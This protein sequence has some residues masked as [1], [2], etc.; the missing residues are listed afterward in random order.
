VIISSS[1]LAGFASNTTPALRNISWRALDSD[2]NVI[3]TMISDPQL[4]RLIQ[5]ILTIYTGPCVN[6][7]DN[8]GILSNNPPFLAY[9]SNLAPTNPRYPIFYS[10]W[11]FI[12]E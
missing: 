9:P 7:V 8:L 10:L 6:A 12:P 2:A 5:A 3:L 11:S 4:S 1:T